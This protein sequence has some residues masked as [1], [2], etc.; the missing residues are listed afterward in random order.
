M[1]TR[2]RSRVG[3]YN[4]VVSL[5]ET[6]NHRVSV[7][8][9]AC[10]SSRDG[11]KKTRRGPA[12][13]SPQKPTSHAVVKRVIGSSMVRVGSTNLENRDTNKQLW[14][15]RW[16]RITGMKSVPRV[17]RGGAMTYLR[18]VESHADTEERRSRR[19]GTCSRLRLVL[20]RVPTP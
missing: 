5:K 1:G 14:G 3:Q 2:R 10:K 9:R 7:A 4:R 20:V 15:V 17:W 19:R 8:P 12:K 18:G 11:S 6:G 16:R 13:I